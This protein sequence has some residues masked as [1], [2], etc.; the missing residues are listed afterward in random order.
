MLFQ[1][2]IVEGARSSMPTRSLLRA[3]LA[4]RVDR[5]SESAGAVAARLAAADP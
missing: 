1:A 5:M 4:N 3:Q 2:K